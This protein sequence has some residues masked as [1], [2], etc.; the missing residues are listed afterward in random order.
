MSIARR[1]EES[2][3]FF[4]DDDDDDNRWGNKNRSRNMFDEEEDTLEQL[5]AK[6]EAS[7]K[8][9]LESLNRS[10]ATVYE[11]EDIGN[12]TAEVLKLELLLN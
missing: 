12:R 10:I 11:T 9:Q 3:P 2:N 4:V 5:V 1:K 8:R 7:E 6:R